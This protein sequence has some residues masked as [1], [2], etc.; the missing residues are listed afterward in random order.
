MKL[1]LTAG[2]IA[3]S[4]V[5]VGASSF[6]LTLIDS[7]PKE[8]AVLAESPPEIWLRFNQPLDIGK[9][10]IG[11]R[12]PTGAVELAKPALADSVSMSAKFSATLAPGEYTVSWLGTP[13]NDHAVRGRYKFTVGEDGAIRR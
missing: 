4:A 11:V 2:L 7:R 6:H 3:V 9:C 5:L 10:G 12:G 8:G 13:I 1:G